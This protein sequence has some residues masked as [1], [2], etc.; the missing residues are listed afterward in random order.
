VCEDRWLIERYLTGRPPRKHPSYTW[1]KLMV[2]LVPGNRWGVNLR[3]ALHKDDWDRLRRECYRKA[4]YRCEVC[5]GKGPKWPVEC[6]EVWEYSWKERSQRL[7]GLVALCP[8]CHKVKHIGRTLKKGRAE[9][10]KA[11]VRLMV[12]NKWT[13]AQVD[14][15]LEDAFWMWAKRSGVE[16]RLDLSWLV[17]HDAKLLRPRA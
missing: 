8:D 11:R 6:H 5:G 10:A 7:V 13:P 4:N 14:E 2:E 16:W 15:Y 9:F 17:E 12:I 3:N 1:P